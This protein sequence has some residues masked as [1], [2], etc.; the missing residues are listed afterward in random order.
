MMT[1]TERRPQKLPNLLVYSRANKSYRQTRASQH[2]RPPPLSN[3][4][5]RV[6]LEKRTKELSLQR[7][8]PTLHLATPPRHPQPSAPP[9][10]PITATRR[11]RSLIS[12]CQEE[13][14]SHY[15]LPFLRKLQAQRKSTGAHGL[16]STASRTKT[17]MTRRRTSSHYPHSRCS[18]R[19]TLP[20]RPSSGRGVHC[21]RTRRKKGLH[22][23]LVA[24][25]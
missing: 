11:L 8:K 20:A 15:D 25:P 18:E 5:L 21:P 9:S 1:T 10:S 23:H 12:R 13:L 4:G 16:R 2:R 19:G 6:R 24:V 17:T 22:S 14:A 3:T 7:E